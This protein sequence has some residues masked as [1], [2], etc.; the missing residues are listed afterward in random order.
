LIG[1]AIDQNQIQRPGVPI[2]EYIK[3]RPRENLDDRKLQIT[4]A[5]LLTMSSLLECNDWNQYSRGN[6]ERMYIIEDWTQ[7]VLD[8]PIKGFA[9]WETRPES[10]QYGRSFSYCTAGV[11]LLGRVLHEAT[12]HEVADYAR[13]VLFEPL[14]INNVKWAYSSKNE[15]M[16]GG[17]LEMRSRDLAKIA[18][19]YLDHGKW[20]TRRIVSESWV[21]ESMRPRAVI[22]DKTKYGYLWWIKTLEV[23]GREFPTIYMTGSGGNRVYA[24]PEQSLV[25]VLTTENFRR[26]D[27][28]QLSDQII[29]EYVLP[30]VSE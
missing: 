11:F 28:H 2:F 9:P 24:F 15:E 18:Q 29:E 13:E 12:G 26:R 19:L 17:G 7:F 21:R 8:L 1:I 3:E 14:G 16:T 23:D 10:A 20:G 4:I 6:E 27:A 5:D 30:T 22:D 25:V